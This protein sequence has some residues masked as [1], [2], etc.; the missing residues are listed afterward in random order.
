MRFDHVAVGVSC[1][2]SG[3]LRERALWH[4]ASTMDSRTGGSVGFAVA[5]R[6]W[7][8]LLVWFSVAV[9]GGTGAGVAQ[10]PKQGQQAGLPPALPAQE[11][12]PVAYLLVIDHSG[13]MNERLAGKSV[14]RWQ[15]MQRQAIELVEKI[16]LGS[17]L[18]IAVFAGEPPRAAWIPPFQTEADRKKVIGHL[19]SAFGTPQGGTA[20]YDTLGIAFEEAER[21]SRQNPGQHILVLA[22]TDGKDESSKQ[23]NPTTLRQRFQQLVEQNRNTWLFYTRI[24]GE[25]VP[26]SEIVGRDTP[27]A[28]EGAFRSPLPVSLV[29]THYHLENAVLQPRQTITLEF[30]ASHAIWQ[31]LGQAVLNFEFIPA[32]GQP[33]KVRAQPVALR[34]GP[35]PVELV[36]ENPDQ[37]LVDSHYSGVLKIHYPTLDK[38]DI[39][40]ADTISISFQKEKRIEIFD[41]RPSDNSSFAVGQ[42]I[43]FW[44]NTLE[45][46]KVIWDFGDGQSA[47]GPEVRHVY[48]TAGK[49]QVKVTVGEPPLGPAVQTFLVDIVDL[50]LRVAPVATAVFS[51]TTTTFR[52]T[53]RGPIQKIEWIIDGRKYDGTFTLRGDLLEGDIAYRF[54][55]T[56]DHRLTVLGYSE[57][58][59]VQSEEMV[60][61]VVDLPRLLIDQPQENSILYFK[62]PYQFRAAIKGPVEKVKWTV[63]GNVKE[64]GN[65]TTKVFAEIERPVVIVENQPAALL[66]YVFEEQT[67]ALDAVI[68]ASGLLPEGLT[69][70]SNPVSRVA[71]KV[72]F[73]PLQVQLTMTSHE[74][75]KAVRF[76][77]QPIVFSVSDQNQEAPIKIDWD[78]GDG[79]RKNGVADTSVSHRYQKLGSYKVTATYYASGG[80]EQSVELPVTVVAVSPVARGSVLKGSEPVEKLYANEQIQL[81]DDSTGDIV[82]REWFLDDKRLSDTSFALRAPGTYTLKLVVTGPPKLDGSEPEQ[83]IQQFK[84]VVLPRPN[85]FL[86]AAVLG[87]SL[88]VGGVSVRL[89]TGNAP[90]HWYL[91]YSPQRPPNEYD[92]RMRLN[93]GWDW[94]RKRAKIPVKRL[95]GG[96]APYWCE[97]EG[98]REQL[99]I[100]PIRTGRDPR[101]VMEFSGEGNERVDF[102]RHSEDRQRIVYVLTDARCA[103]PDYRRIYFELFMASQPSPWPIIGLCVI[104]AVLIAAV[105]MAYYRVYHGII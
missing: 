39:K 104:F 43:L 56:G 81:V 6:S 47:T 29:R 64:Q 9:V 12:T 31:T 84:L 100:R 66:D 82:R 26:L 87:F 37:L 59:V 58:A 17:R 3:R 93:K 23:W 71:V 67:S 102:R 50:S 76:S 52:C 70:V 99:T 61:K 25:G 48:N 65:E 1:S 38:F 42:P 98:A 46:A 34:P 77:E 95:L 18:W 51:E 78:F 13:S 83:S 27:N 90:R 16:P 63:R 14:T 5:V 94:W 91:Y 33:I 41:R 45:G 36:V 55:T 105:G 30:L 11:P 28:R 92:G 22:Y 8:A 44:V 32:Q 72:D 2:V 97:Q 24:P 69:T 53:G 19:Q 54:D 88:V 57:K 35:I 49:R 21:L 20:L 80:R 75:G 96:Y 68:E 73:S 79:D 74:S 101:A 85:H 15:E 103:D 60:V 89:L 40:A 10:V 86:F 4:F 62:K 7:V